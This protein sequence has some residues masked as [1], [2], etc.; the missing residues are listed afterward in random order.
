[1]LVTQDED[2]LV[3]THQWLSTGQTFSGVVYS[4]Q[5][6]ITIGRAVNNIELIAHVMTPEEMQNLV[7][8][9]PL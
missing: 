8:R 4:D 5:L 6:G 3:I 7:L 1:M 9:I 2:F